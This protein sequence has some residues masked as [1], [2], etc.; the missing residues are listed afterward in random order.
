MSGK[1]FP[2]ILLMTLLQKG[3]CATFVKIKWEKFGK[4]GLGKLL[5]PHKY[6]EKA[7]NVGENYL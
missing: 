5:F 6:A 1:K 3:Q 2:D 7:I 4:K